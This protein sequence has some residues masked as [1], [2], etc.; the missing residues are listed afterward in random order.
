MENNSNIEINENEIREK[1]K[2]DNIIKNGASWFLWIAVLSMLNIT[3]ILLKQ[4]I[5]FLVGLGMNYVILGVFHGI[6]IVEEIDLMA[7]GFAATY[8]FSAI[9]IWFWYKSKKENHKIYLAGIIIYVLDTLIIIFSK[10]WF[11][12][13][14]H[15]F[16]LWF[17]YVGYKTLLKKKKEIYI[18]TE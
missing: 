15:L 8:L 2:Q 6:G 4:N 18:T 1:I 9:Y 7:Y 16:A 5:S 13:A 10:E 17:L 14:F 11:S 3:F 12:F